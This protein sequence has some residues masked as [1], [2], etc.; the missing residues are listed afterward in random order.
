MIIFRKF[1]NQKTL[2]DQIFID[3]T[4]RLEITIISRVAFIPLISE[5]ASDENLW[6][7]TNTY[8]TTFHCLSK[9]LPKA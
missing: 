4:T 8:F 2:N 7:L 6:S 1:P 3:T 5:C 9:K